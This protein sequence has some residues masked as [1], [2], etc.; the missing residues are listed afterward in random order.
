MLKQEIASAITDDLIVLDKMASQLK[1]LILDPI[2]KTAAF[3]PRHCCCYRRI[4]RV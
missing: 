3:L 4:R 2:S 1:N